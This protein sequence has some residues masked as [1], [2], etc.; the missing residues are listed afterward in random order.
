[1]A[2]F[3]VLRSKNAGLKEPLKPLLEFESGS[4]DP[5]AVFLTLGLIQFLTPPEESVAMM[6]GFFIRQ[7]ALGTLFGWVLG[8]FSAWFFNKIQ[9]EYEGLYPV[10]S[11][12]LVLLTYSLTASAGGNGFLAVYLG[13]LVLGNSKFLHKKSL[14]RFHDGLAWL[15]QIAMFLTL[16]LLVFPS[17]L[18]EVFIPGLILALF[19]IFIGRPLSV[20][21][22]LAFSKLRWREKTLVS[23]VG[24]RGA[25][26]II[27]A[28]FPLLAGVPQAETIF[29]VVFFTVLTSVLL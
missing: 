20:W 28:T 23:W 15:M 3:T 9:L 6:V 13:G 2:V 11:L 25:V 7:M 29:N 14:I 12:A 24:L 5:M 16:G 1:A 22:T 26:P 17:R 10:L 27:L 21:L 19:L 4:N 18:P 8:K